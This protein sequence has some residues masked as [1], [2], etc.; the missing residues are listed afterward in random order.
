MRLFSGQVSIIAEE[1][2]R[3]LLKNE[4]LEVNNE[5]EVQL[6]IESVLREFIR[7]DRE[8]TE[9]ARELSAESGGQIPIG[10]IKRQLAKE[11]RIRIG[12]ESIG[13]IVDQLIEAFLHSNFVEEVWAE[14]TA[15]R[16]RLKP[17]LSKHMEIEELLDTEVRNKIKN[18]KE[19]GQTWDIEYQRVMENLKHKK[20]LE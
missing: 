19:G 4:E 15:L 6:D 14:D 20:N 9:R 13:Y 5:V 12:D 1:M 7:V 18:I 3:A 10:R 16:G 11:K 8:V 17:I 2:L